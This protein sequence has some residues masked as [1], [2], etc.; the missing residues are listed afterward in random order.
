MAEAFKTGWRDISGRDVN[1]VVDNLDSNFVL[2]VVDYNNVVLNRKYVDK[3]S[4]RALRELG[5]VSAALTF[6]IDYT[7]PQWYFKELEQLFS[8]NKRKR[9]TRPVD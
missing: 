8:H 4:G 9:L 3:L 1:V 2:D 7:P 5:K 6:G